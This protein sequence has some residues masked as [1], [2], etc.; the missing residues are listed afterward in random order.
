[1]KRRTL[2]FLA[3][4]AAL[5]LWAPALRAETL[6]V[7]VGGRS[8]IG[9]LPY[10][11]ADRLGYFMDEDLTVKTN[12]FQGGSKS[13]EALVGGSVDAVI[14]AYENA[15]FMQAKGI[16]IT[17]V[18]LAQDRFGFVFGLPPA[19]AEKYVSP[20]DLKGLKIGVTAPGSAI[21]NAVEILLAKD[22][23]KPSDVSIIGVGAGATALA[24]MMTGQID[25]IMHS[26]P[27]ITRLVRDNAIVPVVDS[28]T[29][30][31]QVYLYGGPVASAGA[32]VMTKFAKEH[33][34]A[35]QAFVNG[36]VRALKWI[37][38]AAPDAIVA[39][40]PP[41]FY[42]SDVESYRQSLF[43]NM[44]TFTVDGHVTE[45]NAQASYRIM[46]NSGRL[47]GAPLIDVKK[48]F[49]DSFADRANK[50]W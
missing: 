48:T 41:E 44:A 49:D 26:D 33:Q 23:L 11:I 8:I 4:C 36:M 31:G 30:E 14:G 43:D 17:V 7:A 16:D 42:G 25:G 29:E 3:L 46:Q 1:M 13:L 18:F 6:T 38:N 34:A 2:S 12:E 15:I 21:A 27:V 22:G 32:Y 19:R 9:Y 28:R 50:K 5:T 24:A 39:T 10:T 20:K 35:V 47:A 45:A 40:V 37:Q